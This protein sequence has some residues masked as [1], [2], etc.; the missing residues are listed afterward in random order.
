[1]KYKAIEQ[2]IRKTHKAFR[3]IEE[4]LKNSKI[5]NKKLVY[6]NR[7]LTSDFLREKA[8]EILEKE[9]MINKEGI[10]ISSGAYSAKPHHPGKG[11]I[12]AHELIVCDIY[13]V[14]KKTKYFADTSRTYIKGRPSSRIQKMYDAVLFAQK[15]AIQMVKPGAK[16]SDIHEAVCKI[17]IDRG[18]DVSKRKGFVHSTGHGLGRKVHELPHINKKSKSV[19]RPG[20]VITI[21]PG[22]YYPKLGGVR[23]ED[24]VAVTAR[25][26]RNL[27]KYP[28]NFIIF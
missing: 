15:K 18:F 9:G 4:I 10:I 25:G 6:N 22:L 27:T 21:E 16:A 2:G 11:I 13:P 23:I 14:S 3:K 26:N 28:K 1:M 19:L 8:T 20:Y 7:P 12:K 24:V 5:K 17:F